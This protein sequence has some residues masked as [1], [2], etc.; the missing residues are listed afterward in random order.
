MATKKKMLQAAAGQAGGAGLDITDVF[1]T[2]LLDN[3]GTVVNGIDLAGEGGLLWTKHRS[4]GALSFYQNHFLYDTERGYGSTDYLHSNNTDAAGA[5]GAIASGSFNSDGFTTGGNIFGGNEWA[6]WTFR[7]APKF[8]TCVTY[9]GTGSKRTVSHNLG[10]TPG[11]IVIKRTDSSGDNWDVWHRSLG[12]DGSVNQYYVQLNTTNAASLT[13][14]FGIYGTDDPTDTTFTVKSQSGV[15]ASGG[16]YVA[17]LFAHNDG[18][19]EFGPDG[20]Q[21]IIK[22]GSFEVT[23]GSTTVN[24]GFEPQFILHK[25]ANASGNW[26]LWDTMRGYAAPDG[27]SNGA[28]GDAKYLY[29]DLTNSEPTT[30]HGGLTSNGFV[31]P[32][33]FAPG[34]DPGDTY[35]YMAIRRGP[36][37]QPESAT[38]V[39]DINTYSGNGSDP[40][41]LTSNITPDLLISA[42]RNN[43]GNTNFVFDR[44]RGPYGLSTSSTGEE[45]L[46][47]DW[48]F[49]HNDAYQIGFP[50]NDLGENYVDW[51]WKRAPGFFDAVAYSGNSTAGRTVSH[52]L[53]VAPEMMWVKR[54]DAT[55]SWETYVEPLGNTGRVFLNLTNAFTTGSAWNNTSPTATEFTLGGG[56][57]ND[58]GGNYIA[59]LFATLPGV[60]KVGSYT[61]N[62]SSQTINA[63]FTSG[64][65]FILI[66]RTDSTGDWY[67]WDTERGIVAGN[68]PYL[69]LNTTD[70]EVTSTDWVDPDNSGFIVNGT[71]INASSAEYIF[72]AVS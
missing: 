12:S 52:N 55:S 2:Y 69:E 13:S 53:G 1:S 17:Y 66:K 20:D 64:A 41:V 21:D 39:F 44:M 16:T 26:V 9:T 57:T 23:T 24:V 43:A 46:R 38:E 11:M 25:R 65:R 19:G 60:S 29:A 6:S 47:S 59:Y 14:R 33:N 61:G 22:C 5:T 49:D 28:G 31:F 3:S 4:G 67:V 36:L 54:R 62:G 7:K 34:T 37:A 27:D 51:H 32:S 35:I 70:A 58:S 50:R 42:T 68:D 8:F 71:T 10:S 15:N 30:S 45:D 48:Q 56:S 40:R 63:G 18:D 72:Y